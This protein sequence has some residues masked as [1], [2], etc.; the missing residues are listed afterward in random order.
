ML[1]L[2]DGEPPRIGFSVSLQSNSILQAEDEHAPVDPRFKL[3]RNL[4][5]VE[6]LYDL[7][8]WDNLRDALNLTI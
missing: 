1:I 5:S 7:G 6:N 2:T 3:V 4:Q 8:F